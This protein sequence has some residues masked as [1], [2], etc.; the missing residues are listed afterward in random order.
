MTQ[1]YKVAHLKNNIIE[2]LYIYGGNKIPGAEY[3]NDELNKLFKE[4][5]QNNI[6]S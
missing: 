5:P 2:T 6:F 1:I 3:D 4:N